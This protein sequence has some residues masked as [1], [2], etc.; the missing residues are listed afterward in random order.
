MID[1]KREADE[2][3]KRKKRVFDEINKSGLPLV[4]FGTAPS[5]SGGFLEQISA[6]IPFICDNDKSKHGS[7]Q[8]GLDIAG[9]D[10]LEQLGEPYNVLILV[11]FE[12]EIVP[13][14]KSLNN[15]PHEIFRLDFYF[16]EDDPGEYFFKNKDKIENIENIL[17]DDL[18]RKTFEAVLKYRV[19]RDP[20]YLQNIAFERSAQYFPK[21]LDGTP[22][23]NDHEIFADAGAFTGDTVGSFL[24]ATDGEYRAIYAFEPEPRSFEILKNAYKDSPDIHVYN[25]AV[26]GENAQIRFMSETTNSKAADTGLSVQMDTLDDIMKGVPVSF[27][28]MDVEGAECGALKGSSGLIKTYKPKLA[29]CAYHSDRDMLEVPLTVLSI[30]PDYKLY[31]RH[32]TNAAVETVC[33]AI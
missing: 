19:N 22:F 5:E 16:E 28:K 3:K 20:S 29:I 18:S 26:G 33:Y 11:P 12:H 21:T 25:I 14:L 6:P 17:V 23:L 27:I 31:M 2:W 9:A 7:K 8:W 13:Q 1:F 32:Y 24:K 30:R 15:P 10:S 4:P